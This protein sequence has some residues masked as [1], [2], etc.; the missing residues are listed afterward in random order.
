MTLIELRELLETPSN[1][2]ALDELV[3]QHLAEITLCL[4]NADVSTPE[5]LLL[6]D[7]AYAAFNNSGAG[8][9]FFRT[10]E[11]SEGVNNLLRL[12]ALVYEQN[13]HGKIRTI[14]EYIK[15]HSL[16][17]RLH[18]ISLIY[19]NTGFGKDGY[20]QNFDAILQLLSEAQYDPEDVL[21][22]YTGYVLRILH[23]FKSRGR[24]A[25]SDDPDKLAHFLA[26]FSAEENLK[27]FPL[28]AE[29]IEPVVDVSQFN[30]SVDFGN[31]PALPLS[32]SVVF[33]SLFNLKVSQPL[34]AD[35][36]TPSL[37]TPLGYDF[38][39]CREYIIEYG[40]ADFRKPYKN[41]SPDDRALIYCLYNMRKHFFSSYYIYTVF[42]QNFVDIIAKDNRKVIFLDLGCGPLT[43]GIALADLFL[44]QFGK[45]IPM[46][47]VGIDIAPAM[48]IKAKHFAED[49]TL[50]SQSEFY[51]PSQLDEALGLLTDKL[52]QV[53]NTIVINASYLFASSSLKVDELAA[54]V[55][56]IRRICSSSPIY[57]IFQNPDK[58]AK[59]EKYVEWKAK[60]PGFETVF[61]QV[62]P[63]QY[64]NTT[65]A[66]PSIP[67]RV[68]YELLSYRA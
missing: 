13:A 30:P 4:L 3:I 50:F 28:L 6:L 41:L 17:K 15:A 65:T 24:N 63:I 37:S 32:P 44:T 45:P 55:S 67:E 16:E 12:F 43:S 27:K 10:E 42:I 7:K 20:A 36:R 61:Q 48:V 68:Y 51:F 11:Y 31:A 52:V 49:E 62:I 35:P 46:Q 58:V 53:D 39:Y 54:F 26:L 34:R 60:L 29:D 18:A 19:N 38:N 56:Q 8:S 22:D 47:Y 57:F 23:L 5:G 25:L 14:A 33:Q 40:T 59:N 21:S 64:R 9:Q 66:D 1:L 2:A